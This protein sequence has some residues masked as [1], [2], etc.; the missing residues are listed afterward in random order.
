MVGVWAG[1]GGLEGFGGGTFVRAEGWRALLESFGRTI[2]GANDL[3][4]EVL[5]ICLL[6]LMVYCVFELQS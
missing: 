1:F 5:R 2:F 4:A 6:V 3:E